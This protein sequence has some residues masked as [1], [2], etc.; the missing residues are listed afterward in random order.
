[1]KKKDKSFADH[2]DTKQG[3]V[4]SVKKIREHFGISAIKTGYRDCLRCD[5]EFYSDDLKLNKICGVCNHNGQ[6]VFKE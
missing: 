3:H 5:R 4:F 1:M 6:R 2:F